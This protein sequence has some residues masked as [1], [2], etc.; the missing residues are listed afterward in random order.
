MNDLVPMLVLSM[1]KR[2]GPGTLSVQKERNRM[3]R[4]T[5]PLLSGPAL[6]GL[7]LLAVP[8]RAEPPAPKKAGDDVFGYSAAFDDAVK[9]IGQITP[10]EFA[11][12][13]PGKAEYLEKFGW[14]STQG[15]FFDQFNT[16]SPPVSKKGGGYI[17]KLNDEELAAFKKN[18]FVV[19]ERM[20]AAS[21]SEMLYRVYSRDLPV[22]I[23]ADAV[24]QAWHRSYDA[25]LEELEETYL[26]QSLN[27]ILVG[28]VAG[29]PEAHK[30]YGKGVLA[31]GVTDADYF[32][33]VARSLLAGKPVK[34]PLDQDARVA[35]T[36]KKCDELQIEDF[37]LFGRER[38][39]DFSQFKVRGHYESSE[40]L[41]RYFRAMMWCGR[42]DLRVAGNPEESSPRELGAAV[43]LHDLLI[44][45]GKFEQ[46]QQFDQMIQTFVGKT[47]SMTFAQLGAV[48]AKGNIKSPADVKDLGVLEA[49]Q[50]EIVS[51]KIGL[52]H[53]RSDGYVSPFG[54]E[55]AQL[56]RSFTLLGQKFV[57]DSWVT[58]KVVFDDVIWDNKKVMRRVPSCLDVA[59]AALGND[60]V[61]PDLVDRMQAAGGREFRDGLNYQ[62]NLA[63]VRQVI[64]AQ[65]RGVWDEN[66][67]MNW[68]ACLRELSQPTTDA[69]YPEVMRTRAWAMKNVNTQLASWTQL[70]HD[71]ILYVKQSYTGT[72]LCYYPA[73]YVEAVP[74]FWTRFEKM[75]SRA[76][77]LIEKTPF[78]DRV[79]EKPVLGTITQKVAL[80]AVQAQQAAFFRNFAKQ[81]GVLKG[82]AEKEL[83]QKELTKEETEFLEKV[84]EIVHR[85]S[86][87]P[88]YNG[89]YFGLFY[90]GPTDA[91]KWDALV[92][93]VHTDVP[94]P[95]VGDPGC[96]LTQG[97]GNVDFLLIAIDNGKDRMVY[98]GPVLSHY[99]FE[100][101][102]VGRKSDSE[103]RKEIRD[104]K[105]P[106]RPSWTK[107]Y[108][109]PG[110]NKDA[111]NYKHT[112]DK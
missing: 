20:G 72:T 30:N 86:G 46:W 104:G 68:L 58:A 109:V 76:A 80:K 70:R 5:L 111:K 36:L 100:M 112:D 27:E 50:K 53:I 57:V 78:P 17:F 51:G 99:E 66:L 43:I 52:Q 84:V 108:L 48:L 8:A 49:L 107:T 3:Q 14:D 55:K 60:A 10:Q 54:A 101:P 94:D 83:A 1:H 92:A 4:H 42:I 77:E 85:G 75:A 82:I 11:R 6:L 2:P 32:L 97:V 71:T 35:K 38:S 25:M 28:M 63:A 59:F 18:G 16:A 67:Y 95:N 22:Y 81:I 64:D 79:V 15:K 90:K 34:S 41:K 88:R 29:L 87:G 23:S 13:Y 106:P 31:E 9:Q 93:D 37:N 39:V 45:A 110:E 44:K 105:L 98:G 61:V 102:G 33:T 96:V 62:H 7:V 19:S 65:D 73:G 40:L 91:D 47:D 74:H 26:A 12:R 21:F 24:L 69:K 89:W 103:W 56:P